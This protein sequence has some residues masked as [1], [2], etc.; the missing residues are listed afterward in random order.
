MSTP[1]L[2]WAR[3]HLRASPGAKVLR[4][5]DDGRREVMQIG[6]L[7][8]AHSEGSLACHWFEGGRCAVHA[9][10]PFGCAFFDA[11]QSRGK[12]DE[13]STRGL[14]AILDDEAGFG[15]YSRLWLAL[16]IAG[17]RAPA[18]AERRAAMAAEH[19]RRRPRR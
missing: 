12:S 2:L 5:H 15:L 9:V 19:R 8:P 10:A 7:V 18:P 17:L 4:T 6:T 14:R 13:L 1:P 3:E 11:H 16:W